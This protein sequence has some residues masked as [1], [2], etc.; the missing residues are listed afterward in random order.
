MIDTLCIGSGGFNGISFIAALYY[1]DKQNH[2][3]INNIY[4]YTGVSVGS[5]FVILFAIG[6][7]IE[8][9]YNIIKNANF[10]RVIPDLNL[11]LIINNFGF[12]NGDKFVDYVKEVMSTKIDNVNISFLELYK[13]TKKEI[14]IAATNFSKNTEKIFNY[15]ETPD[16][17]VI[18][19]MR[20]S[21]SVPVIYTPIIY[22]NDYFIDGALLN[23]VYILK[24]SNPKNT[25]LV[26]VDKYKPT[27]IL[28]IK[29]ILLGSIYIMSDN[30]INKHIHKYNCLKIISS[31]IK[32]SSDTEMSNQ[33][34][35]TLLLN[36]KK[37]AKTYLKDFLIK[38][39]NKLKKD[40]KNKE[41]H[42]IKDVLNKIIL[43]IENNNYL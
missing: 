10:D 1:L 13:L 29:D 25:L 9:V 6:F 31:D 3:N 42:I 37:S 18:L 21:I 27:K 5:F 4:K 15:K 20:M 30:V 35:E 14:H 34:L 2:I 32:F 11:D 7:T 26:F 16:L 28:S 33:I 38:K 39:I 17:P 36:G 40:M 22:E 8:E 43:N 19:A 23:N 12:D 41:K 24:N